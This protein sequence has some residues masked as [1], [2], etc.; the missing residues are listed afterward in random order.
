MMKVGVLHWSIDRKATMHRLKASEIVFF[1]L[2]KRVPS[3]PWK[4]VPV[5]H[6]PA[7]EFELILSL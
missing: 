4:Q 2:E 5:F 3:R 7:F 6:R 1:F